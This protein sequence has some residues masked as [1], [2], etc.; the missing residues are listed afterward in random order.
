MGPEIGRISRRILRGKNWFV[1]L[2]ISIPISI[3]SIHLKQIIQQS[4]TTTTIPTI[5]NYSWNHD[6]SY[7]KSPERVAFQVRVGRERSG[8]S[9]GSVETSSRPSSATN[10][11]STV[12]WSIST[13]TLC[14]LSPM[15]SSKFSSPYVS[16]IL[17]TSETLTM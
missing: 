6:Q 5:T 12:V 16:Y 8:S 7:T 9:I 2:V 11:C 15:M 13:V 3:P 1:I 14:F 17:I 4:K 10:T